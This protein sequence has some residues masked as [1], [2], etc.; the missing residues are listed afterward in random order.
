[1]IK[2]FLG[3]DQ[4]ETIAF[5][6][7]SHSIHRRSSK[8][9]QIAPVMLSQLKAVFN[10][11]K[12]NLQSTEF[13]FSRFLV[14]HLCGYEG[15]A[16]FA[17]CDIL[18]LDDIS[19]LWDL[20]DDRYAIM[21]VQ[22]DHRPKE[23][24]KFLGE[25]Q[26]QYEKKNWSSVMLMNTSKCRVLTPDYVNTRSGL[27]LHRFQWLA[28]D[29]LIGALPPRWNHLVGYDAE[30]PENELGILHF[31]EGGPYFEDYRD[32]QYADLWRSELKTVLSPVVSNHC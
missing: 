1:M 13:S 24:S 10:R 27:E 19:K 17:D 22:H 15:W 11:E 3:Y 29:S 26:T 4:R 30:L 14:P 28:D 32:C 9:V 25:P 2:V 16:L 18:C 20:K 23:S 31:T 21:C 5:H 12:N 8:A 7:A 6:V